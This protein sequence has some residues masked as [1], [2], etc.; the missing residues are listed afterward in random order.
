M[1]HLFDSNVFL[2]LAQKNSPQRSVVLEAVRKLRSQ[3]EIIYYTPQVLAEFW[4]VCTRPTS[5]RG[6]FGLTAEQTARKAGL[7][8]KHF[9]LLPDNRA[10]FDEWLR[11]V[12]DNQI[13]G[14]SVHDAKLAA[15]MIVHNIRYLVTFNEKDFRRFPMIRVVAPSNI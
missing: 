14:V 6:G 4:N 9:R 11:L 3:N 5:A 15:S 7:V 10:T 13:M 1:A 2:R 12:V 8:Q